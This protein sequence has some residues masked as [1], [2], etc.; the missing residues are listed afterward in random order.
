M[1]AVAVSGYGT[2]KLWSAPG[3]F[4]IQ[5][6]GAITRGAHRLEFRKVALMSGGEVIARDEQ[7]GYSGIGNSHNLYRFK[8]P[9]ADASKSYQLH[10]E[11]KADGGSDSYGEIS[12]FKD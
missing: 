3:T 4:H 12:V 11:I 10:A 8:V 7:P 5:A 6:A 9:A 2:V 1:E